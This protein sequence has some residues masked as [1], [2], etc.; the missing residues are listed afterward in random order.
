LWNVINYHEAGTIHRSRNFYGVL[1]V[2]YEDADF[3][4]HEH[5]PRHR[6]THGQI[7]HGFQ[8]L[9][10]QWRM[11][12]TSYYARDSG[13]GVAILGMRELVA[14]EQTEGLQVGVVGLGTGT[15]AVY[16][17]EGDHFRFYEINREV[18]DLSGKYFTHLNET[19]A[20]TEV[21]IGDARITMENQI[22]SGQTAFLDVLAIDAFSS[23][24][25]PVHLLTAE[26]AEVYRRLLKPSGVLAI[27]IS[28]RFLAL[29]PITR[30]MARHLGWQVLQIESDED[31]MQGVFTTTWVLLTNNQEFLQLPRVLEGEE[32]WSNDQILTWTDDYSGLWKVL[33]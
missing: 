28:N 15:I 19:P 30:G 21:L 13:L 20:K 29:E 1:R 4:V 32:P 6:L 26:C 17:Q 5:G 10:E 12:P 14:K 25:I 8:F 33:K 31:E 3:T 23:D 18:Q 7:Q 11:V 24:A 2:E 22:A 16:G 9:D 27:H